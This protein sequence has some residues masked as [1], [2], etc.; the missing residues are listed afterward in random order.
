MFGGPA[1]AVPA[2]AR[3]AR[4]RG[5]CMAHR[6]RWAKEGRPGPVAFTA[7]TGPVRGVGEHIYLRVLPAQLRLEMQYVPRCRHQE[8]QAKLVPGKV[9][10]IVRALAGSGVAS[11]LD[12]PEEFWR[13]FGAPAGVRRGGWRAFALDACYR[14]EALAFGRGWDV[15]YPRDVWRLRNVGITAP[16]ATISFAKIPRPRL[17][18]LAKRWARPRLT[19]GTGTAPVYEGVRAVS[20]F[21]AF[22]AS[23]EPDAGRLA[24]IDR[25]LLERY[26]ADLHAELAGRESRIQHVVGLNAVPRAIRQYGWDDTLPA[27]AVLFS[28]DYPKRAAKLP[29][30]VAGHVMA[31]LELA[32]NLDRW[33]S[34]AYRLI[35]LIL[36]RRGPRVSD[37]TRLPFDCV[38]RDPDGAPYLRYRNHK[39]GREAL[40]PV[41]EALQAEIEDHQQRV[42]RQ[43]AGGVPVLFPRPHSNLDGHQP[44]KSSTYRGALHRWLARCD[45]RD[46]HGSPAHLTP[47][48]WRHVVGTRLINRDVPQHVVQKILDHDSAE[49]TAHYARLSDTTVRRHWEAARKV[50][51]EGETVIIDPGGP[52]AEAVWTRQGISRATQA[53]PNG[54]CGL[55]V[56]HS[57]PHA[58]ACLAPC[59]MFL[60][61][62]GF[63]PQHRRHRR[64]LLQVISAAEAR[65]HGRVAEMNQGV[66][67]RLDKILASLETEQDPS[68]QQAAA[69]AC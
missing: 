6:Q 52:L 35:T 68:G 69:D 54:Y 42:P 61:T 3:P 30:P 65:G 51:A 45:I 37:A 27:G 41:D 19:C 23:R 12:R 55:P 14:V 17:K 48:Q 64:E 66:L 25:P 18:D 63:L 57:C 47:H 33:G 50:S 15:E 31:Q 58:N 44:V 21:A 5:M 16:D 7:A 4:N 40:V 20:R 56:Q 26:L 46:E 67:T 13:G 9:Q 43:W 10:R 29:R 11:L 59:P 28:E 53:L 1:C 24:R 32:G 49:M 2:C 39:M 38:V 60:T 8:Q 62:P 34:P 22:L 36:M